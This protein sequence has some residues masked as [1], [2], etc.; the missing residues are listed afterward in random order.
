VEQ[1]LLDSFEKSGL[2][3]QDLINELGRRL[4]FVVEDGLYSGRRNQIGNDGLWSAPEGN[5]IILEVKTTD[6]YRMSMD[7]IAGYREKLIREQKIN[8]NSSVLIVVGREDTGELE[9]QVR[10]S[11]HAWDIRLISADALAKMIILKENSDE[12]ETGRKIR[13]ILTPVEYTRVDALVDVVFTTATDVEHDMEEAVAP[14]VSEAIS[15][16]AR[17]NDVTGPELL[18]Q[19][20]STIVNAMSHLV[21]DNL[22]KRTRAMYWSSDRKSRIACTISKRYENGP[23]YW[24]AFHPKWQSFLTDA[25]ISYLV[26]GCMGRNDAF[27]IPLSKLESYLDDFNT[28]GAGDSM[29]WHIHLNEMENGDIHLVIPRKENICIMENRVTLSD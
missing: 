9:A 4:E 20:R 14:S 7:T 5:H 26:L 22:L 13:N 6:A 8:E 17:T 12:E 15:V 2:V 19:K 29:Y 3:L 25:E 10:G 27:A 11:R 23:G 18:N 28:T 21:G 16:T 1:C 24:Y